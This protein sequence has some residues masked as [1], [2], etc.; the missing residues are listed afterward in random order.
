MQVCLVKL[1]AR[2]VARTFFLL[3]PQTSNFSHYE[4]KRETNEQCLTARVKCA[5]LAVKMLSM[6]TAFSVIPKMLKRNVSRL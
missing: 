3:V 1:G 6:R 5:Q 2:L 4:L